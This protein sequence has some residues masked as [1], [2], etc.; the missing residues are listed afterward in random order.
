MNQQEV[1]TGMRNSDIRRRDLARQVR[2]MSLTS[3]LDRFREAG[4]QHAFVVFENGQFTLSHPKLLEPLRAFMELSN[5]FARHEAVFIGTE[6]GLPT[7]FFAFVHDTRRGLSQGGLRYRM[8]QSVAEVLEDGLRLSQG[9]TR[10]NALAGL[11]W[12]GGKGILP[13]TDHMT[14]PSYLK[15]GSDQ[16]LE[17]FRGYARFVASLGGVY[18][19]AEDVGTKTSDMDAMLS[20]NRFQTCVSSSV[21]GSGN[22][23]P[24]TARGVFW[25]M[26]AAWR[27][28]TGEERLQGVKVAVQGAGNVGGVLIDLLDR[29]GAEVWTC[30]VN[31]PVLDELAQ[32]R[33]G[34]HIVPPDEILGLEVDIQAPCAIG[35]Q[36]NVRTI[37]HLKARLVCGAA[38]N[39][40]GEPADAERLRERGIAF[41]PDYVCNRMGI[42]NCADEWQGY[43]AEDVEIAAQRLYPDTL[44]VL[45]HARNLAIST[46]AAA[47]ELADIAASELHPLLGH[48]GR[49]IIDHLMASGWHRAG[50]PVAER[51]KGA[52]AEERPKGPNRNASKKTGHGTGREVIFDPAL[53]E[54]EQ[55]L[56]WKSGG[57]KQPA[58][59]AVAA[60]PIP[61]DSRPSL[62]AFLSNVLADVRARAL[63]ID[64][65]QPCRRV[66]GSDHGGLSLQL[67]VERSLPYERE[68]TGR[69]EFF[70][71]CR[72]L[73][74]ENDATV[75][76]HLHSLGIGFSPREW[77]DPMAR[78][79]S[80]VVT[81]LFFALKDAGYLRWEKRVGHHCPR[82]QTVLVSSEVK[83]TL[84][85]IDRRYR[86]VFAT[87][88]GSQPGQKVEALTF[89][90][91]LLVGAVALAVQPQG[92]FGETVGQTAVN[93]VTNEDLPILA[94]DSLE[95]EA[96]FLVPSY[97]RGDERIARDHGLLAAPPVFDGEGQ[98]LFPKAPGQAVEPLPR[99]QAREA[100]LARLGDRATA[101]AGGWVLNTQRCRRC[102]TVVIP[103]HSE[104]LFVHFGSAVDTLRQAL[105]SG[106]VTFSHPR[107]RTAVEGYLDNLEPLCIS[108]QQWWGNRMPEGTEEVFSTWF[109]LIAWSL[110]GVGWPQQGMPEPVDEVFVDPDHLLRWVIPSQLASLALTGRPVFRRIAVHGAL[111]LADRWLQ[112][113]SGQPADE[114]DED[115]FLYRS[116]LRP[117]RRQL[118]NV[119]EPATLTRRFGTDALRLGYL[120]CLGSGRPE[121]VTLDEGALRRARRAL[122]RLTAQISGLYGLSQRAGQEDPRQQ[123]AGQAA[124]AQVLDHWILTRCELAVAGAQKD[125]QGLQLASAARRL[126]TL[127]EDLRRYGRLASERI[128]AGKS[129]PAVRATLG[130]LIPILGVG[131]GPICPFTFS[132]L[133]TWA[134]DRGL[135]APQGPQPEA[136]L[137]Q[138]VEELS[139]HSGTVCRL[140]APEAAV[141]EL[142]ARTTTELVGLSGS[143]VE[144]VDDVDSPHVSVG[145]CRLATVSESS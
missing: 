55:R 23:S 119:V 7:L 101:L 59:T 61:T 134:L 136:W 122:H 70:E 116:R 21:G 33:P 26:Q 109:S 35:D 84:L 3:L 19:T 15:E 126:V 131:F 98:V 120:L 124:T 135:E 91:E 16:R 97:S 118:G 74:N 5:D 77:L 2:E 112:P 13:M 64:N 58:T 10:K 93:P 66:M 143:Q 63:E 71:I 29:A 8:Y 34:V 69:A 51:G 75:R 142:L 43:L 14:D 40:L 130:S 62:D 1:H 115:R 96:A 56:L 102:E 30:D 86:I 145:P 18:Y 132:K 117:M 46:T 37:P 108:R 22:P 89:F 111:H 12:G 106:A 138:L 25:A 121:V 4:V 104:Q 20:Q 38:N 107:W 24:A 87:G 76:E 110:Q 105:E 139:R 49:R 82:C 81:R 72:D 41:V 17:V 60:A 6:P 88:D 45:K 50:E 114:P 47:D 83:P 123:L 79:G 27:F 54:A 94:V 57:A 65:G 48:R 42:T 99:R 113:I 85:K 90:P 44:R 11:W 144:V 127:V 95:T 129:V 31:Q 67:A 9:M 32:R 39:I 137:G 125:Y 36:I 133:S 103:C 28:L 100:V 78:K 140:S 80:Q 68:E 141:R 92:R 128:E 53:D 73:H 52:Q